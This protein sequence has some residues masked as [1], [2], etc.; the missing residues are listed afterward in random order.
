VTFLQFPTGLGHLMDPCDS[1][2]HSDVKRQYHSKLHSLNSLQPTFSE[3][4]HAAVHA[5]YSTS[6]SSI[7]NYFIRLGY[8]G[9]RDP[10]TIM[11]E[12]L[13]TTSPELT[14]HRHQLEAYRH[15]QRRQA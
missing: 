5:Y 9:T 2:F 15:W 7:R 10:T 6:E 12:I 8:L 13:V 14:R 1:H 3:T 11:H 4:L